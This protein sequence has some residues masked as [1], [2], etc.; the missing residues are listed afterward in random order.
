M[1]S[2]TFCDESIIYFLIFSGR[3]A[4]LYDT[5]HPDWAPSLKL[6][7]EF[8]TAIGSRKAASI[9][10]PCRYQR[11]CQ[12]HVEQDQHLAAKTS[13]D[14]TTGNVNHTSVELATVN[15]NQTERIIYTREAKSVEKPRCRFFVSGSFLD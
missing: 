6:S 14:L 15:V 12:R 5:A 8:I 2:L 10:N 11:V 3:P 7:G 4:D 9:T 13:V 1:K